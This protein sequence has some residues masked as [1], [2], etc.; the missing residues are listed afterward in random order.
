MQHRPYDLWMPNTHTSCFQHHE[1]VICRSQ[2]PCAGVEGIEVTLESCRI[3][4][5]CVNTKPA[6][7]TLPVNDGAAHPS[8]RSTGMW[9][10]PYP[11]V[12]VSLEHGN[13]IP[14]SGYSERGPF[15]QNTVRANAEEN[16]IGHSR[17]KWLYT[18]QHSYAAC[19]PSMNPP[20]NQ[21]IYFLQE[22]F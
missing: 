16:R 11:D 6:L 19:P 17:K 22:A 8:I 15:L 12:C 3:H 9:T 18:G 5:S 2:M 4:V 7:E 1:P 14:V 21:G 13:T 10:I 20:K